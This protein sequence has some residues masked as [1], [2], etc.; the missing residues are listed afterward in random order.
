MIIM[1]PGIELITKE[2]LEH[3]TKHKRNIAYDVEHNNDDQLAIAAS[4]LTDF[5]DI[6]YCLVTADD[7]CPDGWD[8]KIWRKM[9]DKPYIERLI[10]A[11]A[12]IAAEIDRLQYSEELKG[13]VD[14]S[15]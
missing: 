8:L 7:T 1:K 15:Q 13:A 4:V 9:W 2:R 11:G 12:L 5:K 10:I 3:F 14:M 6:E